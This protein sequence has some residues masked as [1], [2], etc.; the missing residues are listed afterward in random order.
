M[1]GPAVV[2]AFIVNKMPDSKDDTVRV[3]FGRDDTRF[4]LIIAMKHKDSCLMW[5]AYAPSCEIFVPEGQSVSFTDKTL[6]TVI[7]FR[8]DV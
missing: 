1:H 6:S 4:G 2:T 8:R 5:S 7:Y 3:E